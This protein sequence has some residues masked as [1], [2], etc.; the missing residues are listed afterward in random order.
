MKTLRGT[1][2][3]LITPFTE[4]GRHVDVP[5]LRKLVNW[6]IEEGIHGLIPL[7]ST[8]EFLSL[9]DAERI[10]VAQTVIEAAAGRVHDGANVVH[11][12]FKVRQ[13][14]I[15]DPVAE[16]G[17]TFVELDEPR[18]CAEPLEQVAVAG[19]FPVNFEIGQ[20]PGHKDEIDRAVADHLIGDPHVAAAGISGLGQLHAIS[21][22]FG[23]GQLTTKSS[24]HRAAL[25]N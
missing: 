8:G 18:E 13:I 22:E 25:V 24:G 6:Q 23:C 9:R 14:A 3:V 21:R 20:K 19:V 15:V 1:Y 12:G 4:D 5:A 16:A 17:A 2:T 11:P 7:G 10:E